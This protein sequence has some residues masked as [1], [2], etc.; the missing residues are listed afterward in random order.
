MYLHSLANLA[1]VKKLVAFY[2][3]EHNQTIHIVPSKARRPARCI[4]GTVIL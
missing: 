2:V 1:S 3:T 4:S